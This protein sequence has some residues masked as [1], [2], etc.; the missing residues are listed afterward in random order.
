[1]STLSGEAADVSESMVDDWR[2]HLESVCE[3]YQLRDIFNADETGIFYRALPTKSM[4]VK[5]EE[6][7]GGKKYISSTY[8]P[9]LPLVTDYPS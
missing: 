6:A 8:W 5:G 2:R 4:K 1:M 9:H 3:G 7:R